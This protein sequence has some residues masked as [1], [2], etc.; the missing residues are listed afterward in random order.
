MCRASGGC[1]K[2]CG[3]SVLLPPGSHG[4]ST[5]QPLS[6]LSLFLFSLFPKTDQ[7]L[8]F[9]FCFRM[10]SMF[11]FL[12]ALLG[13]VVGSINKSGAKSANPSV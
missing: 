6:L 7:N 9:L 5:V 4:T 2:A 13:F 11:F 12:V 10:F 1:T 3:E 8:L